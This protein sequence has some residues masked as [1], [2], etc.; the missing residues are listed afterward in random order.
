MGDTN[1]QNIVLLSDFDGTIAAPDILKLLFT[2]FA[3][4]NWEEIN[5]EYL[6]GRLT[7]EECLKLQYAMIHAS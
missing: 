1:Y 3:Q 7:L 5:L 6:S 4:G 2:N